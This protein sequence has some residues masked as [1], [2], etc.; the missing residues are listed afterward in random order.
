MHGAGCILH[1]QA[2]KELRSFIDSWVKVCQDK[3]G[4]AVALLGRPSSPQLCLLILLAIL[5]LGVHRESIWLCLHDT[6]VCTTSSLIPLLPTDTAIQYKRWKMAH[7]C[8]FALDKI[9]TKQRCGLHLF[10]E[11]VWGLVWDESAGPDLQEVCEGLW[12]VFMMNGRRGYMWFIESLN[13]LG[14]KEP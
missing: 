14:W 9:I 5:F 4:R 3:T 8:P 10:P 7:F 13:V 12:H 11:Y 6:Q 2:W 1:F